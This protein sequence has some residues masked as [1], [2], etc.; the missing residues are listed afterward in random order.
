MSHGRNKEGY[1]LVEVSLALLVVAI[2]LMTIFALIPDGLGLSRK[3]VDATEVAAFADF[4]FASLDGM[5]SSTNAT[6]G[7][8]S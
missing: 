5:A 2:G 8:H 4:V 7:I 6:I 3:S 1:S